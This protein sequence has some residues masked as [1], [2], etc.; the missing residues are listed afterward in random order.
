MLH[1]Y[2]RQHADLPWCQPGACLQHPFSHHDIRACM[3]NI[4]IN[5]YRAHNMEAAVLIPGVFYHYYRIGTCRHHGTCG[6][7]Y[8][9]TIIYHNIRY[10]ARIDTAGKFQCYRLVLSCQVCI[11]CT[12]GIPIHRGTVKTRDI[13]LRSSILSQHSAQGFFQFQF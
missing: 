4:L 2:S 7:L 11:F 12:Y 8:Y 13:H 9:R 10:R 1:P 6:Y 3:D 5:R